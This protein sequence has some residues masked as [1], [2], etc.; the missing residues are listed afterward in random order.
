MKGYQA[1]P[2]RRLLHFAQFVVGTSKTLQSRHVV[3]FSAKIASRNVS[4]PDL[5]NVRIATNPLGIMTTC[6]SPSD[7]AD[8]FKIS[9]SFLH[10][11]SSASDLFSRDFNFVYHSFFPLSFFFFFLTFFRSLRSLFNPLLPFLLRLFYF[12][13][14]LSLWEDLRCGVLSCGFNRT[15]TPA[16][17]L[18]LCFWASI[19]CFAYWPEHWWKFWPS[20]CDLFLLLYVFALLDTHSAFG[21]D[22]TGA[23]F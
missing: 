16:F 8:R 14:C 9:S 5:A 7:H 13:F 12:A 11:K 22:I 10:I 17:N 21:W 2:I 23:R 3:M 4:P 19:F 18:I 20:G 6:T 15:R 1:N